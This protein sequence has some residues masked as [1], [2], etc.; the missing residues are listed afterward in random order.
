MVWKVLALV[1]PTMAAVTVD[2]HVALGAPALP[3]PVLATTVAVPAPEAAPVV[4]AGRAAPALAVAPMADAAFTVTVALAAPVQP[5][6]VPVTPVEVSVVLVVPYASAAPTV[7][8]VI[9]SSSDAMVRDEKRAF[10]RL[11][12]CLLVLL[13]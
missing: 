2:V 7:P 3:T 4:S 10:Y 11:C 6:L 9:P 13:S 5:T 8:A 12:T 1:V